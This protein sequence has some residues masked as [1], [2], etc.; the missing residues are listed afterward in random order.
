MPGQPHDA[1][2]AAVMADP[3][4]AVPQIRSMLPATVLE[5]LDLTD[6]TRVDA[7]F[8]DDQLDRR[9]SD[10][11]FEAR[12]AG[13]PALIYLLFEH[14]SS[15]SGDMGLRLLRY[16]LRIWERW[17]REHPGE[18]GLPVVLPLVLYHGPATWTVP[19]RL[20]DVWFGSPSARAALAPYCPD[21]EYLLRDLSTTHDEELR[22]TALAR[23]MLLLFKHIRDHDL[24]ERLARWQN[25]Y[26]EVYE[27]SG[28][29]GLR[30][31][32][33]YVLEAAGSVEEGQLV[34]V[35]TQAGPD[36]VREEIMTLAEQWRQEG[37]Q[38]GRQEGA[39]FTQREVLLRLLT[40]R[41]GAL[42]PWV[43]EVV[44]SAD[45]DQLVGWLDRVL[46]AATPE[47]ALER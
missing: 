21:F 8:V 20:Q 34:E 9:Q 16:V 18:P 31:V 26:A 46:T 15:P 42:P 45:A 17:Q 6:T 25:T 38:R 7:R 3:T 19:R 11:L 40:L 29:R 13:A 23:M 4:H 24:V 37:L 12:L 35:L 27:S 10:L 2:F 30:L 5:H 14:Q 44:A 22:G 28:L 33:Q 1:L 43:D 39:L 36:A 47:E 32:L 41:F